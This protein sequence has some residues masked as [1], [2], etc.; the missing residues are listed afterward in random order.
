MVGNAVHDSAGSVKH[1]T[2]RYPV[3]CAIVRTPILSLGGTYCGR[4]PNNS[5][6]TPINF[7]S[8]P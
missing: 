5:P 4:Q 6:S 3:N 1:I 7:P 8:I 2:V